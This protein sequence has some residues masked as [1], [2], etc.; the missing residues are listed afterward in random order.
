VITAPPQ[1][2]GKIGKKAGEPE[3]DRQ[4]EPKS[5]MAKGSFLHGREEPF[6]YWGERMG[7]VP[8]TMAAVVVREI[9]SYKI[10]RVP[11]EPPRPDEVLIQVLVTGLCRTD[12]KIIEAGHRDLVLPRIPGE[13]VVGIIREKGKAVADFQVGQMV[14]L[15]PG[16]WCGS[17]PACRAGAENLCREMRIMGFHRDG[18]FADY[19][20][21]PAQSLIPVPEGLSSEEAVFAEPLSCCLNALEQAGTLAGKTVGI[22]G[23]GPAGTLLARAAA[24]RGG[25]PFSMEPNEPRRK[26]TS[27]FWPVPEEMF[28]LAIVAVGSAEAYREA[29]QHLAPRGL[30]VIFSGLSP[31]AAVQSLDLNRIHYLEQRIAGAY[32]CCYRHGEEALRMLAEKSLVVKDLISHHLP[33]QDLGQGL[34]IVK[35]KK[36][37]KVLLYP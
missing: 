4:A 7:A 17:C 20:L 37:M 26:R 2:D 14:Y 1:R 11:V 3:D 12:L 34:E 8:E 9:G 30:L 23:A 27:G 13:E 35:N 5:L 32:G 25:I 22:W 10:T 24:V 19:V 16:R 36:G 29:W 15:Y 31:A 21:A 28:D 6:F 33:L 18:G